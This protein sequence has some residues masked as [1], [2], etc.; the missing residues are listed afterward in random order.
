MTAW[1][2]HPLPSISMARPGCKSVEAQSRPVE[3]GSALP[4][5]HS[6]EQ[7]LVVQL[8]RRGA[9]APSLWALPAGSQRL[10]SSAWAVAG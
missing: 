9:C 3:R 6:C 8:M 10:A 2:P 7:G 4:Q 1:S 5:P